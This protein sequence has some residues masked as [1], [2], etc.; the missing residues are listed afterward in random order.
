MIVQNEIRQILATKLD[1]PEEPEPI[2]KIIKRLED[3]RIVIDEGEKIIV[4]PPHKGRLTV[5]FFLASC[6]FVGVEDWFYALEHGEPI[7]W[8]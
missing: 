7:I 3:S 1:D 5:K 4:V 6:E 8:Q 2:Q